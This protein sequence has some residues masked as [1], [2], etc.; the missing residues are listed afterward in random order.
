MPR[1]SVIERARLYLAKCPPSVSG[2]GGHNAAFVAAIALVKGFDLAKG[3]ARALLGEWNRG[4]QPPWSESELE[5][6][7]NQADGVADTRG[8]G[9][10]LGDDDL[11]AEAPTESGD[12]AKREAASRATYATSAPKAAFNADRLKVV[13]GEWATQVDLLW[14]ANRSVHDPATVTT[15]AFLRLL[16]RPKEMVVLFTEEQSQGQGVWPHD[17]LPGREQHRGVWFLAQ[18][19]DG[20]F[21]LNPRNVDKVT[22]LPKNSRRSEE[23]VTAFRYLVIE[24]DKADLWH[25][26]GALAQLPL[27]VAAIYTSG[28]RSIHALVRVDKPTKTAWDDEKRA[29][30]HGLVVLGA[31]PQSMSAV[32]LTRLPGFVRMEKKT[33]PGG[34]L[35]KLLYLNPEPTLRPLIEQPVCR[36]VEADWLARASAGPADS[37]E[38]GGEW[39]R[40]G[41]GYYAGVSAACRAALKDFKG[42]TV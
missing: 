39:I 31:D 37:D 13:A 29:M 35:Q 3:D 23:S 28:G 16:Y 17:A 15:Q 9:Y 8:R 40:Q 5:H 4:C 33:S 6:K 22:G 30:A 21:H 14:L 19:V 18:P 26:L 10:L 34:G 25:W 7:L 27:R 11:G 38:S 32:R 12:W 24:S 20:Q 36:D 42:A 41:L 2:S 1:P